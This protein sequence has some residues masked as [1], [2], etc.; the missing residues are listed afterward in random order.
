MSAQEPVWGSV[1]L[2]A[3]LWAFVSAVAATESRGTLPSGARCETQPLFRLD[4]TVTG[5]L[6]KNSEGGKL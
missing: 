6:N 3:L 1:L 2:V 4:L 5:E